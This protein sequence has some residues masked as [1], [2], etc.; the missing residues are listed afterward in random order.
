MS[1]KITI[2]AFAEKAKAMRDA[3][4]GFFAARKAGNQP[5]AQR[6]LGQSKG[7][8]RELDA[9]IAEALNPSLEV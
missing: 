1:S 9:M 4:K 6:L 2:E 7:L 8:E 5:E 3:Q